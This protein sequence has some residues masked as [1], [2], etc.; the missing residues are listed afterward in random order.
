MFFPPMVTRIQLRPTSKIKDTVKKYILLIAYN[1]YLNQRG[2]FQISFKGP[3]AQLP[4]IGKS[5]FK[6]TN[7]MQND[8]KSL[9]KVRLFADYS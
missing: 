2:Q 5:A 7:K 4:F 6:Y 9:N 1:L 8:M 3:C